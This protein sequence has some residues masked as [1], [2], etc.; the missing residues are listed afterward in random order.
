MRMA[1][2]H[3]G[4]H[5]TGTT[6]I[7]AMLGAND[8]LL[9]DRGILIPRTGRP[10]CGTGAHHNIAF[11]LAQSPQFD[12]A[13]GTLVALLEEISAAGAPTVVLSSEEFESLSFNRG[14]LQRLFT[15][16][17]GIGYDVRVMLYLRPQADYIESLYATIAA[18]GW[19]VDFAPFVATLLER[20]T[21]GDA[22]VDY[23]RLVDAFAT[24]FHRDRLIVR[25][26]RSNAAPERL[27]R[28][29]LGIIGAGEVPI[30]A[31]RLPGKLNAKMPFDGV[32]AARARADE[33]I[34]PK[35]LAFEPL[36]LADIAQIA[37]RFGPGNTKLRRQYGIDIP[38]VTRRRLAR[39]LSVAAS[40]D[41]DL[42]ARKRLIRQT[43]PA[44]RPARATSPAS[45]AVRVL[46]TAA[47]VVLATMSAASIDTLVYQRSIAREDTPKRLA[48]SSGQARPAGGQELIQRHLP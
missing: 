48:R 8:T 2:V 44:A 34:V 9:A 12:P 33:S 7:Q 1:Y 36:T 30:D 23:L 40:A 45:I 10:A 38:A 21:Y 42:M 27:L 32:L 31:L 5:K 18:G 41:V 6:S 15:G 26:Y 24:G 14:G 4:T 3:V 11:E 37:L 35:S 13:L 20:G 17:L 46:A 39:E 29:F 43:G 16:L 22:T 47:S 28:E 19:P 25:P